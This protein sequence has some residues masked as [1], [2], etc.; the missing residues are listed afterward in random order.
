MADHVEAEFRY[1]IGPALRA[2][3]DLEA[4]T[5]ATFSRLE[6][7]QITVR[8]NVEDSEIS[9]AERRIEGMPDADVKVRVDD[10]EIE[11]ADKQLDDLSKKQIKPRFD[12]SDVRRG[13]NDVDSTTSRTLVAGAAA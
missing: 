8:A 9:N 7:Q 11:S 3:D 10:S 2:I 12:S 1:D 13:A 6:N 5:R 4:Q